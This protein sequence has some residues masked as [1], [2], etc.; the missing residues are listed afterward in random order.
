M[1]LDPPFLLME[2]GADGEVGFEVFE[3]FFDGDELDVVLPEGSGVGFGEI[4]AQQ[5]A[6][7]AAADLAELA[8]VEGEGEVGRGL[9]DLDVDEAP[10]GRGLGTGGPE[11]HQQ[12]LARE[13]HRGEFAQAAPQPFQ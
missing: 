12:L 3:G 11:L 2:Y 1:R 6:A 10:S 13:L 8:S 9:L 7:F 5:I 4:G